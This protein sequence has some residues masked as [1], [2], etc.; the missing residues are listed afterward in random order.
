MV[1]PKQNVPSS[2]EV[3]FNFPDGET[4]IMTVSPEA[5]TEFLS[6]KCWCVTFSKGDE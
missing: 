4:A 1:D 5:I 6:D 2:S 3:T